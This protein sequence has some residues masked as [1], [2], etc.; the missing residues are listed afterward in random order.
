MAASNDTAAPAAAVDDTALT[1]AIDAAAQ[2]AAIDDPPLPIGVIGV[3]NMGLAIAQRLLQCGHDVLVRDIRPEAEAAARQAGAQPVADLAALSRRCGL[4]ILAVVDAAQCETV[5][6][7]GIAAAAGVHLRSTVMVCSTIAPEDV[8]SIAA[9][10]S[11]LQVPCIDA[12][13]SGGPQRARDGTMSLM[14]ACADTVFRRHEPVLREMSSRLIRVGERSGDG[15]RTKLVNNLLAAI[16]LAAAVEAMALAE[17][18]G[19]DPQRTLRVFEQSS[20]QSWIGGDR[21]QRALADDFAPRA[22]TSLLA[23]DSTLALAMARAAG[24]EPPLGALAQTLFAQACA[25]G[26]ESLDDA[27]LLLSMRRRFARG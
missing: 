14:V 1:A 15:A 17:R 27:S 19:L 5:L 24:A 3:G 7:S 4:L 11:A 2:T 16:N 8:E 21:L 25:E 10:L 9:R 6:F 20:A 12:P 22:H 26:L 23:K 18:L 13:M